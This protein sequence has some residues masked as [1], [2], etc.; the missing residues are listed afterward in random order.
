MTIPA[1]TLRRFW[2][3]L[4]HDHGPIWNVAELARAFG[5]NESTV[6]RYLD[7]M[8]GVFMA[9][10]LPPWFENLGNRQVKAPK[11]YLRDSANLDR[12]TS[13]ETARWE[14]SLFSAPRATPRFTDRRGRAPSA[15]Q[16]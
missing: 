12:T 1:V 7:L 15:D 11:L 6:R 5:V 16:T 2:A 3:M 4:A 10:Q 14:R 8:T 13:P 9:L